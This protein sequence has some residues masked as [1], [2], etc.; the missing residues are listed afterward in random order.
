MK[1]SIKSKRE[2]QRKMGKRFRESLKKIDTHKLY[3]LEEAV[4]L[5]KDQPQV[6]FD[7]TVE[8]AFSLGVDPKHS[9]QQVRGTVFLPYGTGKTVRVLVISQGDN[10]KKAEEAGADLFGGKEYIDK[11]TGGWLDFDVLLITPDMMKEVA[12][13]GK[14]LGSKGLMPS[15]KK[16]TVTPNLAQAIKEIK[17]GRIEYRVDKG[18]GLHL[19][20]GK[21]SFTAEKLTANLREIISAIIQA[22][23]PVVKGKYIKKTVLSTT[24]GPGIK[25][26]V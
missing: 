25:L 24:M 9:D 4:K 2:K 11:I 6:K 14:I 16:G 21:K 15:P 17:K 8:L 18:G 7:E 5:L 1:L 20:A 10:L 12:R 26:A 23:P 22:R 3:K 13:L 19:I